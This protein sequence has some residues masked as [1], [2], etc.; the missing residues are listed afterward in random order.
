MKLFKVGLAAAAMA[1]AI[2][3]RAYA[4]PAS[5]AFGKCIVESST[6]KD[7]IVFVQWFFAAL[8]VNPNVQSFS[9]I[10][11]DQRAFVTREA[12][13]AMQKLTLVDCHAEAVAALRQDGPHAMQTGFAAFGRVAAQELMTDPAVAKQLSAF[14]EA[15]DQ[16]KWNALLEEAKGKPSGQ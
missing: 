1:A 14:A 8:S 3:G 7:R 11:A 2:S 10:T 12:A 4:G 13:L 15:T 9:A 6:G 16:A 5:D